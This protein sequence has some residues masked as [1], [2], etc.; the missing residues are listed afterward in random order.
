MIN[1]AD[2]WIDRQLERQTDRMQSTHADA[3]CRSSEPCACPDNDTIHFG[4]VDMVDSLARQP[5][6]SKSPQLSS[7]P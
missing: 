4:F 1:V 2:T 5:R 6:S 7:I 3:I